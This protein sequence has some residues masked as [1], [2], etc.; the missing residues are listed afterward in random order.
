MAKLNF[1]RLAGDFGLAE[2]FSA[3]AK[4]EIRRRRRLVD[5]LTYNFF[6]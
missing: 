5:H 6:R 2:F 3:A 4:H 1:R